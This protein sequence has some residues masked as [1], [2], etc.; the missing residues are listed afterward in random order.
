MLTR[1]WCAIR[2]IPRY[3]LLI[4]YD[5]LAESQEAY[6]RFV[7][8]EFVPALRQ[9]DVY[10]IDVNHVVWGDYPIRQMEFVAESLDILRK[11]LNSTRYQELETRLDAYVE[12]YSRKVIP[13]R[14]GFQL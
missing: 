6:Y 10:I 2:I 1:K 11:A 4:A 12:N 14:E 7:T 5:I 3:R 8:T 13:Y 9:M